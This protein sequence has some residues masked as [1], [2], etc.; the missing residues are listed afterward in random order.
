MEIYFPSYGD[1]TCDNS[2]QVLVTCGISTEKVSPEPI[3]SLLSGRLT[4]DTQGSVTVHGNLYEQ[5]F[6]TN[7]AVAGEYQVICGVINTV[8]DTV[9][10]TPGTVRIIGKMVRWLGFQLKIN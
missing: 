6:V 9:E 8:L 5:Q 10:K 2:T 3:F 1:R 4:F 7:P